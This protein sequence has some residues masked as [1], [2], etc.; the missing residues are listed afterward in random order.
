LKE[1]V[2]RVCKSFTGKTYDLPEDGHAS[3]TTYNQVTAEVK[4]KMKVIKGLAKVSKEQVK[5]YL[6]SI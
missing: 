2:L 5:Q 6:A 1:T 4:Q 3:A